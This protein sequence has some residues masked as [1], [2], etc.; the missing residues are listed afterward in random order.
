MIIS[1]HDVPAYERHLL[2]CSNLRKTSSRRRHRSDLPAINRS[3]AVC[4]EA[5]A[6]G[7]LSVLPIATVRQPLVGVA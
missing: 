2:F 5:V 3:L 1:M 7:E 4:N 6:A